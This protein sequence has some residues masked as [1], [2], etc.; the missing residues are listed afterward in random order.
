MASV[1]VD[2]LNAIKA[3]MVAAIAALSKDA[4][5]ELWPDEA[6]DDIAPSDRLSSALAHGSG[7]R[8][9]ISYSGGGADENIGGDDP[10]ATVKR[11][12]IRFA[13]RG[14]AGRQEDA[15][16][17]SGGGS[18]YGVLDLLDS[19]EKALVGHVISSSG[20]DGLEYDSD[21]P[22]PLAVSGCVAHALRLKARFVVTPLTS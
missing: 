5:I 17:A 6:N 16:T 9:L 18:Y 21:Y 3:R 4:L 10:F 11:I 7:P 1:Y 15:I 20:W 8:A 14:P 13:T 12:T 19:L 2:L 22:I